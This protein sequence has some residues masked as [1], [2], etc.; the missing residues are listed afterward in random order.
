MST[1]ILFSLEGQSR[2]K[3]GI[4]MKLK[5]AKRYRKLHAPAKE[6]AHFSQKLSKEGKPYQRAVRKSWLTAHHTSPMPWRGP[7]SDGPA[8]MQT[9][10]QFCRC[11]SDEST[12]P[13]E[14][15]VEGG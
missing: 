10:K 13:G 8:S 4:V 3:V 2:R 11:G 14:R 12:G 1:T 7:G 9:K 15:D 6:M 5:T